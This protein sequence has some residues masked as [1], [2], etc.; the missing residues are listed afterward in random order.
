MI[1]NNKRKLSN[2]CHHLN[3][4]LALFPKNNKC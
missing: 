3:N 1:K 4:K 2:T